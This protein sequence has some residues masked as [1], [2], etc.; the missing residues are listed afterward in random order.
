MPF[1]SLPNWVQFAAFLLAMNAGM[2]NVLSLIT[3]LH[4]SISHMTGN[5]SMLAMDLVD[6]KVHNII[7]LVF[8]IVCFVL[9]SF[10]SGFILGNSQFQLGR[11]YG[12]PL[13]LVAL[14]IFISWLLLPYFPRYGLLWACA[15]MGIQNAMV[16]HYKGTIIRTTHLSGV[17]TDI[18]LALGYKARG[19]PL[20][21]RRIILHLLI[22]IG[23]FLGGVAAALIHPLLSIQAFLVPATLS[24]ILS[25]A[26]WF[27][28]LRHSSLHQ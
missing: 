15:A 17:L 2:I 12:I 4:Q 6:W 10:Y 24:L 18:G 22:L 7:Y 28:Y 9:G 8:V 20:D 25:I 19:L 5:V 26:Y 16:S 1:Q 13:S 23:F 3:V 27:I 21:K 14:F 11:R